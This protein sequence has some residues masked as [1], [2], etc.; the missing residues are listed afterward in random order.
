MMKMLSVMEEG[1]ESQL[2]AQKEAHIKRKM[3]QLRE[4]Q[5]EDLDQKS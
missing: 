3:Q 1:V 2:R 4:A 5:K